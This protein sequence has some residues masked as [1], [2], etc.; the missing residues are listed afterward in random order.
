[1][2][3]F[4]AIDLKDGQVV[5]LTQGDYGKVEVYGHDPAAAARRFAGQGARFLHVVDLDGAKDG[6]LSNYDAVTAILRA[7]DLYVEV[8]GGIRDAARV[9]AYLDAGAARVIL[10]S[11]ALKDQPFLQAMLDQYGPAIAV[12]VDA[13]DGKVATEG[14]LKTSGV[15]SFEFCRAVHR[16]GAQSVIYTDIARDGAMQGPNVE[17]VAR[18]CRAMPGLAVTASGGVSSL[19]DIRALKKAG[20]AAAIVGK[21]LYNGALELPAVLAAAGEGGA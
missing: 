20:A 1:M 5:R 10:G 18:L 15:D 21:A 4:P 8:G 13:R 9:K 17:A 12:G 6:A 11:A 3:I 7:A 16:M 19:A 2:D 14:W